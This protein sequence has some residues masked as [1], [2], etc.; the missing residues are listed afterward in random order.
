MTITMPARPSM[1]D[2]RR[3]KEL[4]KI[5][6]G[7]KAL[8]MDDDTYRSMLIRV[9]GRDSAGD[10]DQAQR[11]KVLEYLKSRGFD[12]VRTKPKRAGKRPLADGAEASKMRALWLALYQLGEVQDS[13]EAAL[14]KYAQRMTGKAA[15]QWLDQRDV[16]KVINTLRAWAER[17]GLRAPDA[18][19]VNRI[20]SMRRYHELEPGGVGFAAKI[21]LLEALWARCRALHGT[22]DAA[23]ELDVWLLGHAGIANSWLLSP[24]VADRAIERL[25]GD[26]RRWKKS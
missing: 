8:A 9:T 22:V 5:H 14:A 13:S 15:L 11:T 10:L 18:I 19:L 23:I 17:V 3:K 12:D 25:G 20:D 24:D 2:L 26:V 7:K 1:T 4:A 6:L 21:R 16:A